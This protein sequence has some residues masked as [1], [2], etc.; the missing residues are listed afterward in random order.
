MKEQETVE[1]MWANMF[2]SMCVI[3]ES[4]GYST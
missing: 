2:V 3:T 1:T 4:H